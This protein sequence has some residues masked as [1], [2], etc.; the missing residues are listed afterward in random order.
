MGIS[1]WEAPRESNQNK[2]IV[3]AR[4][5]SN[6]E[7]YGRELFA[8]HVYHSTPQLALSFKGS[9]LR[10][11]LLPRRVHVQG[12]EESALCTP[13]GSA[14]G[15]KPKGKEG[16]RLFR[17]SLPPGVS[18]QAKR[19]RMAAFVFSLLQRAWCQSNL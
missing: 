6:L 9:A 18:S 14:K 15:T 10:A 5:K 13:K 7:I 1:F 2:K 11:L 16:R 8:L 12:N 3:W 4:R 17:S 19:N